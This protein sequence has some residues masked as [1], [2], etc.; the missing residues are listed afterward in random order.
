MD[1][2]YAITLI[3]AIAAGAIALLT[4]VLAFF[5]PGANVEPKTPVWK[6][7]LSHR[8]TDGAL[9]LGIL[10]LA[11]SV[12]V[13]SHWAHGPGTVMPL[14][15]ERLISEHEAF[16]AVVVIFVLGLELSLYG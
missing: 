15:F 1:L 13:H 7:L 16:P 6:I 8:L 14:E 3:V 10:S 9:A 11:I 12:A 2:L 5:R 4:R